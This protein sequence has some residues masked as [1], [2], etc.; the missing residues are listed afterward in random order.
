MYVIFFRIRP[1]QIF[2]DQRQI[3]FLHIIPEQR[4]QRITLIKFAAMGK[5]VFEPGQ[6]IVEVFFETRGL[7]TVAKR[8]IVYERNTS[9]K[10]GAKLPVRQLRRR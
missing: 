1:L 7:E 5:N 8:P 9:V 6:K 2:F 10:I 4:H 3:F